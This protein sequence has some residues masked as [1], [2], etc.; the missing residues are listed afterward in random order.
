VVASASTKT[1][2]QTVIHNYPLAISSEYEVSNYNIIQSVGYE[3]EINFSLVHV[4]GLGS[5]IFKFARLNNRVPNSTL[6]R[7]TPPY[8]YSDLLYNKIL[9][10]APNNVNEGHID[11]YNNTYDSFNATFLPLS[12]EG[13]E[14]TFN[15]KYDVILNAIKFQNI[16]ESQVGKYNPREEI[17]SLYCNHSEPYYE[18]DDPSLIELSNNIVQPGDTPIGKAEQICN[19]VSNNL[20]YKLDMPKQEKGALWAYNN[21]EGDCSEF[22]SLMVTL[23]RIQGIP[24]RKVTGFLISNDPTDRPVKGDVY[25]FRVTNSNSNIFGHAWVEYYVPNIGWIAC[26][27]TWNHNSNYFNTFDYLRFTLNVGANFFFP[28]YS[29]ISEF[30]NPIFS[31]TLGAEYEFSYNIK[32]TVTES[33]LVKRL[34]SPL[35]FFVI[36]MVVVILGVFLA[37]IIEKWKKKR[38]EF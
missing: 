29:T 31:Y 10:C 32:I 28:P 8:Q 4:S 19:W 22:S 7:Y 11:K 6:T 12:Q 36:L 13:R 26:D 24:A 15:Q 23:L 30:S 33:N 18:I 35:E 3:V 9:G 27:P 14:I 16:E 5:Y 2:A 38:N 25:F 34:L 17:F 21:L 1:S 20:E 37:I